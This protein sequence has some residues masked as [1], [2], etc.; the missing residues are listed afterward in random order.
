MTRRIA[1]DQITGKIQDGFLSG[2]DRIRCNRPK[3]VINLPDLY[4]T[5]NVL[6]FH[7]YEFGSAAPHE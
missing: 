5:R 7:M 4:C 2:F 6:L 3:N 1:R